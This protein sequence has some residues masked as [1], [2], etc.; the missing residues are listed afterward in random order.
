[1]KNND[2]SNIQLIRSIQSSSRI[3]VDEENIE[4]DARDELV[5]IT[6]KQE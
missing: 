3:K 1:M 6:Q 5:G 2:D 4:V